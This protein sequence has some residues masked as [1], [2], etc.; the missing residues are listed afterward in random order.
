MARKR[1][2]SYSS[3]STDDSDHDEA[4]PP[5]TKR[6]KASSSTAPSYQQC[7]A[8]PSSATT[9]GAY[10]SP[11]TIAARRKA[12]ATVLNAMPE[13]TKLKATASSDAWAHHYA[14]QRGCPEGMKP[15]RSDTPTN[16]TFPDT[17]SYPAKS[18]GSVRLVFWNINGVLT[19]GRQF[20]SD[21]KKSIDARYG[22]TVPKSISKPVAL[23][24]YVEAE[25]PDFVCLAETKLNKDVSDAEAA[26]QLPLL[27][28]RFPVYLVMII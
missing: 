28:K 2:S 16:T 8:G 1:R 20:S 24:R 10:L 5:L 14:L 26:N 18:G 13:P 23:Q 21:Y 27:K 25:D 15:L 6:T 12:M 4:R 17:L 9:D 11:E 19:G 3:A 22:E 7:V